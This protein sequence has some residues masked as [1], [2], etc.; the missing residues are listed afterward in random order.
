M[1]SLFYRILII[2]FVFFTSLSLQA[3]NKVDSLLTRLQQSIHDTDRINTLN[4]L[5]W[6]LKY[7][8]PDTAILLCN[9]ALE[10]ARKTDWKKG[11]STAYRNLGVFNHLKG[12]YSNALSFYRRALSINE[13]INYKKGVAVT[14]GNMGSAYYFQGNYPKAL[15]YYLKALEKNEELDRKNEIA[16]YL[17]NI[18][19]VYYAQGDYSKTLEYYLRALEMN[20][21][22]G[23]KEG[24]AIN[25]GNIGLVYQK[26]GDYSNALEYYFRALDICEEIGRKEAVSTNMGN[27]GFI[28]ANQGNYSKALEYYFKALKIDEEL[29]N[30]NALSRSISEIGQIYMRTGRFK[31]AER[32]LLR[33]VAISDSIGALPVYKDVGYELS[34]LYDTLARISLSCKDKAKYYRLAYEH[35]QKYSVAKDSLFNEEKS[36][37]VGRLESQMEYEKKLAKEQAEH[38]KQ[39]ALSEAQ[40]Q[41]QQTV[42]Y[43]ISG[44]LG[45][46]VIFFI[47]LFNRF[48]VIRNQKQLIEQQKQEVE[49]THIALS[50]KNQEVMDSIR[51]AKRIQEAIL[52]PRE[53]LNRY[54]KN[55]FILYQP[56]DIVAG[57]F[58]WLDIYQSGEGEYIYFAAADCTGHGV[59]GAMVSVVCSNALSK[60]LNEDKKTDT[61][62]LLDRTRELVIQRLS[63]G[64][65]DVKDGMDISL[66]R[67]HPKTKE[68]QWSGANNPLWI[69][70]RTSSPDAAPDEVSG[71]TEALE[72][73]NTP[74]KTL[75]LGDYTLYEIKGDKQPVGKVD[76]P[77]PFTAHTI[78][79][80]PGD[81]LYLFTDGFAD[82]FGGPKGKKLKYKPFKELLLRIQSLSPEEQ[83]QEL[84]RFFAEWK[85]ELEQVD[86][87]CILCMK[88]E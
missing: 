13:D 33:G 34:L 73:P 11:Q 10:L 9:Q 62:E 55:G 12:D 37:E 5:A 77:Q 20:R 63:K 29:G 58:Y 6:S 47:A 32:Y 43:A 31:E 69:I 86:D 78:K 41:Q 61:G 79:V 8:N 49:Q 68:L 30:K 72:L 70:R 4:E 57:D 14:L 54:L 15:K 75:T 84:E 66:A 35:Y 39:L 38:E 83:K 44:G 17:G 40:K 74:V 76:N 22:I 7:F 25:L 81:T 88:I 51:Y 36:K 16:T 50:E 1:P 53:M 26:Q 19:I 71:K 67:Y 56:K 59:P 46:V 24:V 18:G 87:V 80:Q 23:R 28:Y 64:E 3:K 27:V 45:L 42:I 65:E 82:Q 21:K 48:Q 2:A 60:A 85:G 52:P